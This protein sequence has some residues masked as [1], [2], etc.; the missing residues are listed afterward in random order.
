[1]KNAAITRLCGLSEGLYSLNW[2]QL[3]TKKKFLV[4]ETT[5][6]EPTII[7]HVLVT[8]SGTPDNKI[9]VFTIFN[10]K[11]DR[12]G[13]LTTRNGEVIYTTVDMAGELKRVTRSEDLVFNS[14][15]EGKVWKADEFKKL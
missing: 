10:D 15:V 9:K 11:L 8:D 4:I 14:F 1:M 2:N 13:Q 12:L 3:V 7:G 5:V 6:V